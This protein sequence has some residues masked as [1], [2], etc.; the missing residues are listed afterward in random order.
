MRLPS[1]LNGVVGTALIAAA[2]VSADSYMQHPRGSNNKLNEQQNNVR[3]NRRLFDSQNNDNSGY[4]VSN[5]FEQG[6]LLT[7]LGW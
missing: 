2:V 1:K 6:V 7:C 3:N 5:H 4:Q